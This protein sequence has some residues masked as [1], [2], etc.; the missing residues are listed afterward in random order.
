[1]YGRRLLLY[2]GMIGFGLSSLGAGFANNIDTLL[3]VVNSL[4]AFLIVIFGMKK[5]MASLGSK[6]K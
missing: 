5:N 6:E 2:C 3:L 4:L 1:M